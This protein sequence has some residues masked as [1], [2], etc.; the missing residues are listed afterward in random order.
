MIRFLQL[1]ACGFIALTSFNTEVYAQQD[2][3]FTQYFDNTLYVNPAYAGS[4]EV[5]N[6]TALHREQWLD[7][8]GRPTS[9]T[10]SLNSPLS[11]ESVGLGLT[12]V[13]DRVGPIIQTMVYGDFSYT[14]KFKNNSKLAFGLKAGVNVL[15]SNTASLQ[16]IVDGDNAFLKNVVNKV[17]PNFGFGIYYHTKKWFVGLS[18][19]RIIEA[20]YDA[21]KTNI[22][23]R[24]YFGIAG[25][26]AK[27]NNDWKLRPTTNLK[28]TVGTP[29]SLDLSVAAIWQDKLYLG[30][31]YR[32]QA[33]T[34]L[35]V[36][37]QLTPQFKFG[38]ASDFAT[39]KI[40]KANSGT[41]E[42]MLSYDFIFVKK[43]V[44]SPRYF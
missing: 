29:L 20:S 16:T 2:P 30:A 1:L 39:T 13:N 21:S 24:H 22:E 34:G 38:L 11:Y 35:F 8:K 3:Q 19:P 12:L 32:L 14:L 7:F 15:N 33:A 37:Y 18:T 27:L 9:T 42:L 17:N 43:G 25:F 26:V 31:M 28:Y 10:F 41:F 40:R 4:K 6:V 44:R 36:Q 23:R 5:M